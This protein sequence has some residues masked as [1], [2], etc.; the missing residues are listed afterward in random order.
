MVAKK[1]I[2]AGRTEIADYVKS[3]PAGLKKIGAEAA[4][5]IGERFAQLEEDVNSKQESV[6][7]TLATKYVESRKG[8]DERIEKL[9]EENKGLVDKAIGAIKAVI[10]TI[11]E[12][13]AMLKNV[14]S[15]VA[16]VVGD[17]VRAPV[18]FLGNLIA[19]IKGGIVKFKDNFVDHLRKG[20]LSWLF[21][22]L[23][24]GGVEL[25][26]SFDLKGIIKLLASIFGLTWT[27]I[28]NR[29]VKQIG[30]KAM[31]AVEK[32]VEIFT[33]LSTQGVGGLWQMLME[34]L[35]DL[36]EMILEQVK[37][38]VLTKIITAGIT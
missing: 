24:E 23:A 9:Q 11:R 14:L 7:D 29:I 21:G 20:L 27:N 26:D 34:K 8:L 19:G 1:R 33:I 3:R 31:A 38:F 10:N 6:V 5:E 35:G 30:E 25:P 17:I 12:L 28:R 36:K 4:Q 37:D 18:R 16:G 2:A 13:V 32:G 22:A 15:R